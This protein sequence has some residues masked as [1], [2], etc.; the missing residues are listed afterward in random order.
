MNCS[1]HM[2]S[3]SFN[4]I[5][6]QVVYFK[7]VDPLATNGAVSGPFVRPQVGAFGNTRRN[8]FTGPGEF[9]SDMSIFKNFTITERVRAQFQAEFFNVFN[10]PVYGNPN[11]CVDCS[12]NGII[13]SLESNSQMRQ[14]QLGFRVTF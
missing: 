6:R 11:T 3:G 13:S 14:L 1:F 9:L 12:G 7:P 2:L 10:H 8:Q 5:T 4:D